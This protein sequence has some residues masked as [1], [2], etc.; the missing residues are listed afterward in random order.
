MDL[1]QRF[2]IVDRASWLRWARKNHPD[3]GGDHDVFV[4]VKAQVDHRFAASDPLGAEE[5]MEAGP[6]LDILR[7][8]VEIIFAPRPD[9]CEKMVKDRANGSLRRCMN[10]KAPGQQL[11]RRHC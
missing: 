11:C 9:Q 2:E 8:A 7:A 6:D 10:K 5:P 1:L 4:A 3:K